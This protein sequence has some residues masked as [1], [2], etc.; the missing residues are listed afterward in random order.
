[1]DSQTWEQFGGHPVHIL[2][3]M[4]QRFFLRSVNNGY[5]DVIC[6]SWDSGV[7]HFCFLTNLVF[8]YLT[9]TVIF[10]T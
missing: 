4:A 3:S 9:S 2:V 6:M 10:F 1:M 8:T 5:R 7:L